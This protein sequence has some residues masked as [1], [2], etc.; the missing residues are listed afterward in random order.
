MPGFL[1][2]GVGAGSQ[3]TLCYDDGEW[4]VVRVF[5]T[6]PAPWRSLPSPLC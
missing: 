6:L 4:E 3:A 5:A 2:A 1:V